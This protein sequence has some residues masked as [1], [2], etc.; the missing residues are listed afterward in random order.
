[1]E[2][3]QSPSEVLYTKIKLPPNSP[4]AYKMLELPLIKKCSELCKFICDQLQIGYM[5]NMALSMPQNISKSDLPE[6]VIA[7]ILNTFPLF[8]NEKPLKKYKI[9]VK[10]LVQ[11]LIIQKN[12]IHIKKKMKKNFIELVVKKE[13]TVTEIPNPGGSSSSRKRTMVVSMRPANGKKETS[14]EEKEYTKLQSEMLSKSPQDLRSPNMAA[15]KKTVSEPSSPMEARRQAGN[16]S[17]VTAKYNTIGST[18]KYEWQKVGGDASNSP[19]LSKS[20]QEGTLL[21]RKTMNDVDTGAGE[22]AVSIDL[23]I[24]FPESYPLKWK[25]FRFN[26]SKSFQEVIDEIKQ[27]INYKDPQQFLIALKVPRE[28]R[29][30]EIDPPHLH[31]NHSKLFFLYK[32]HYFLFTVLKRTPTF[33]FFPF[34]HP[35]NNFLPL[36]EELDFLEMTYK[37]K[38]QWASADKRGILMLKSETAEKWIKMY[39]TMIQ[40]QMYFYLSTPMSK[41]C[42]PKYFF[43]R[44]K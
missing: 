31:R 22:Q 43:L 33:P 27:A 40:T 2:N 11:K 21:L 13:D 1:M 9:L 37:E 10:K 36:L 3:P 28:M 34:S 20:K 12:Y 4:I 5:E 8:D 14:E 35:L 19:L 42:G 41:V 29:T 30:K 16:Q 39:F 18:K 17:S 25:V 6:T 38:D 15:E 7:P 24:R 44:T 23:K 26:S 32:N